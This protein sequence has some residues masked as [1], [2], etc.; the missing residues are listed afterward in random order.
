[1][2]VARVM[3]SIWATR[4]TEGIEALPMQLIVPLD[5]SSLEVLGDPVA[6]VNTVGAGPGDIVFYVEAYEACLPLPNEMVPIDASIVGI[7][8]QL[9]EEQL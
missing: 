6:A 5:A 1:M 7:I 8:E 3:G 9:G 4:Q 2:K